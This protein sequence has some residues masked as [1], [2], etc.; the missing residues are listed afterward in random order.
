M[1][2][3]WLLQEFLVVTKLFIRENC[4]VDGHVQHYYQENIREQVNTY[5]LNLLQLI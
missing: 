4:N 2:I 5:T 3:Y 1:F